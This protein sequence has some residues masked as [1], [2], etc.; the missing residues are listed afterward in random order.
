MAENFDDL[1]PHILDYLYDRG[2]NPAKRFHCL[3]P[4]HLDRNPSM[5]Y[6]SKRYKVHCFACQADYD[7]FDLLMLDNNLASPGEAL[8]LAREKWGRPDRRPP[9]PAA[10]HPV[11]VPRKQDQGAAANPVPA[12]GSRRLHRPLRRGCRENQLLH[13]AGTLP[14]N[15][16]SLFPGL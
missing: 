16:L 13:P 3:N 10:S 12:G 5:G 7:L 6:D 2:I 14:G 1:R 8:A 9:A 4:A 15:R 11:S